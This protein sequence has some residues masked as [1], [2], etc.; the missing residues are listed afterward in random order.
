MVER[1]YSIIPVHPSVSVCIQDG[2]SNLH[3]SFSGVSNLRLSFSGRGICVLWTIS[4]LLLK[5]GHIHCF[6]KACQSKIK[7]R[8]TNSVDP[9]KMAQSGF[10]LFAK[11]C[12]YYKNMHIYSNIL[13]ISSP[14]TESFQVKF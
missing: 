10:T 9:D 14:K 3:L 7:K 5:F 13:K 12:K 6:K 8:M 2:V 11:L 4:S 1:A